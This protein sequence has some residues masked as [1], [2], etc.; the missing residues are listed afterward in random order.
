MEQEKEGFKVSIS[1][2]AGG[3][4]RWLIIGVLAALAIFLLV[5]AK[6]TYRQNDY[7]SRTISVSAEEKR[8]VKP[9]IGL[10]SFT[11]REENASLEVARDAA[12]K[13]S[14]S[15]IDFLKKNGVE[16]RD[17]KT[18]SYN[19]YPS[20][21][22]DYRP[23]VSTEGA[24]VIC[25]PRKGTKKFVIEET[26]AVKVRKL[27]DIGK[28]TTGATEAGVNQIGQ[29]QFT[30]DDEV[31]E[32]LRAEARE[33]AITKARAEAKVLAG[34]LGVRLGK[35]TGFSENGGGM[36]PMYYAREMGLGG[37]T[38]SM[39]APVPS[40]Q[41]GENEIVASVSLIYEIK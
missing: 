36:P 8:V 5:T 6:S 21:E 27:D 23:C 3:L 25:P 34:N 9:D 7:P 33:A 24:S 13:K 10:I 35:L 30:V 26:I 15:V 22:Y 39:A 38:K 2:S 4:M 19:I 1:S 32:K 31:V 16:S 41:P 12:S 18:T 20:E 37:D 40:I 17:I 28:I 14:Q 29:L 11:I